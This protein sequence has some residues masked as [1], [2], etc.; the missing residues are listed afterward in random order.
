M[1]LTFPEPT[2]DRHEQVRLEHAT[3]KTQ[4][5]RTASYRGRSEFGMG[6]SGT[7]TKAHKDWM[8]RRLSPVSIHTF[9]LWVMLME[10]SFH[11]F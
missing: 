11:I 8:F 10:G 1:I 4:R 3:A 7:E 2:I 6:F 9:M 5:H